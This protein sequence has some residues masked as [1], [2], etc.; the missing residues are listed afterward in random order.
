MI[1]QLA[2]IPCEVDL[3]SEFRYRSPILGEDCLVV[4]VS[5]SGE[6]ADTLAALRE[7]RS[8]GAR[9]LSICNVRE[10]IIYL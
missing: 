3:A 1:E 9:V 8:Q 6:T 10:S 4:P 7:G 2:G 5:Q